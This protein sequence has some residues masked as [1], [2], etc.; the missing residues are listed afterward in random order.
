M[1]FREKFRRLTFWNKA[2]FLGSMASVIAIPVSVVLWRYPVSADAIALPAN[3]NGKV[4]NAGATS[5]RAK[6]RDLFLTDFPFFSTNYVA[7]IGGASGT[8]QMPELEIRVWYDLTSR[9]KFAGVYIPYS[10]HTFRIIEAIA[11][12]QSIISG[13][14]VQSI[15]APADRSDATR[16]D[17][18]LKDSEFS[19]VSFKAPGDSSPVYPFEFPFTGSVYIYYEFELSASEVGALET[20][21]K[22]K[23]LAPQFRGHDYVT[24]R[25]IEIARIGV[26]PSPKDVVARTVSF[27]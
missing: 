16:M 21:F 7:E 11:D 23:S 19:K 3:R 27:K 1:T 14:R 4:L 9:A 24:L 5:F 10:P 22:S 18:V 8:V 17:L 15:T 13:A 2:A 20:A 12:L 26:V 25:H 6:V